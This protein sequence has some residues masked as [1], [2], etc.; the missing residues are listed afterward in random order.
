MKTADY[1]VTSRLF[2]GQGGEGLRISS[3]SPAYWGKKW[4]EYEVKGP[5][6]LR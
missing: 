4:S 6:L 3:V 1:R 5:A 2:P